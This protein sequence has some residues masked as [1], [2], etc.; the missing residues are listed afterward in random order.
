MSTTAAGAG[1]DLSRCRG[2]SRA[3]SPG[4]VI[5][6]RVC[7]GRAERPNLGLADG[8]RKRVWV[9]TPNAV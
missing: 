9:T 2:S 4:N 1:R 3:S 6:D 5:T 8:R 7:D